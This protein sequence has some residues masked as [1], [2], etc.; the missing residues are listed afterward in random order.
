MYVKQSRE[1]YT[2]HI[3]GTKQVGQLD[4]MLKLARF[5]FTVYLLYKKI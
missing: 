5:S 4:E 1:I 2:M 3:H